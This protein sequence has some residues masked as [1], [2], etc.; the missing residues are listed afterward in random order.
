MLAT[1]GLIPILESLDS[2]DSQIGGKD[3][4]NWQTEESLPWAEDRGERRLYERRGS[5][6]CSAT[7]RTFVQRQLAMHP[8]VECPSSDQ[9]PVKPEAA[10]GGG[11]K[12]QALLGFGQRG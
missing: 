7:L 5:P 12:G 6:V 4:S 9:T 1:R 2:G 11:L 3:V 10:A 8:S